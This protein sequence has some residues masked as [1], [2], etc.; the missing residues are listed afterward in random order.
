MWEV[1]QGHQIAACYQATEFMESWVMSDIAD[2][3]RSLRQAHDV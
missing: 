3:L 1:L 2:D